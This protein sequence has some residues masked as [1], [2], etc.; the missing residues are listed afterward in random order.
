MGIT[1]RRWGRVAPARPFQRRDAHGRFF[2]VGRAPRPP[3]LAVE[4][5]AELKPD[6]IDRLVANRTLTPAQGRAAGEIRFIREYTAGAPPAGAEDPGARGSRGFFGIAEWVAM[7][8]A[9]RYLPWVGY[10]AERATR[11]SAPGEGSVALAASSAREG[12]CEAALD[13]AIAFVIEGKTLRE[14]DTV[15][16]WRS[17]TAS[18]LLAYALAV[19]A[20]IAGWES[21][22]DAIFKF[23][24]W[25]SERRLR[26]QARVA[27]PTSQP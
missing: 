27:P 15:R 1:A 19:Y 26:A 5:E 25:W 12:R 7:L 18:K 16:R 2:S 9:Q 4:P 11:G 17:G 24:A 14:C 22:R 23:E 13:I 8:H 6:P 21:R 20:D 10:L 3:A